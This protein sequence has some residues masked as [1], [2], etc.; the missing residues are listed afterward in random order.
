MEIRIELNEREERLARG[1]LTAPNSPSGTHLCIENVSYPNATLTRTP[2]GGVIVIVVEGNPDH[3][4]EMTKTVVDT[5]HNYLAPTTCPKC[6]EV[7]IDH[8]I[9]LDDGNIYCPVD[10][11]TFDPEFERIVAE[12][13]VNPDDDTNA[14]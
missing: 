1:R 9:P 11:I 6:K 12:G 7:D 10:K 2:V 13:E 3:A 14:A 5:I 8:L 4:T